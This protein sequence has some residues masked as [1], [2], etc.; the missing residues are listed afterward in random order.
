MAGSREAIKLIYKDNDILYISIHSL[1]K[2]SKYNG[3]EGTV[4]KIHK[5][6]SGAWAKT[7]QKTRTRVRKIAYDLIKLYAKRKEQKGFACGPDSYLQLELEASFIYEDTPDQ[8][9][10]TEAIKE[11]MEKEMPMDRLVCGD[12]GFGKTELAVRAMFKAVDNSKQVAVLVPTTVLALQHY[13]TVT[14][15]LQDFPVTVRYINRFHSTR[16][17]REILKQLEEGKVDILIGTH[18]IVGKDVK[19][20]DLGLLVI[21]EEQKFGVAVKDKLKTISVNV[22][23]LTLSATPI[24][25]TMHFSLM[26]ARDLSVLNTPPPNRYPVQTEVCR[27]SEE[28][29]RNAIV[30]EV[31]R[32]GQVFFVHNRIENI[33][34][35]AVMVRQLVP[36]VRIGVAHG[37]MEGARLEKVMLAFMKGEFDVLISTTIIESGLDIPNANTIIINNAHFFGLSDLHQ[38]RGRVGRSNRK[39]FA[40]L[41]APPYSSMTK[42]ARKRL[43]TLEQFSDLG[44][45]PNIAI[46]DLEIRGAGD[47][48]GAEQSG[49]ISEIGFGTYQKILGRSPC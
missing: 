45:G 17:Q 27:F 1:H 34:E 10:A 38:M 49:F 25:R 32:G 15:R 31:G 11:D 28:M 42:E 41:I 29:I 24:P 12:V 18:R 3:K 43:E 2:I 6:G 33:S 37:Q 5:L 13:K 40:Y 21:D 35:I 8:E 9:K 22:D 30:Y 23:T 4:P 39:A 46:R 48:L 47:L 14:E 7:K 20:K 19:W 16:Q 26:G 44:S 36:D